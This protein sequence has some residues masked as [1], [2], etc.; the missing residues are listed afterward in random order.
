M[1]MDK[2]MLYQ[3]KRVIKGLKSDSNDTNMLI[4]ELL[5]NSFYF[6]NSEYFYK[7]FNKQGGTI[8]QLASYIKDWRLKNG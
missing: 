6:N 3:V 8:W 4:S 5:H 2:L 7:F 1:T